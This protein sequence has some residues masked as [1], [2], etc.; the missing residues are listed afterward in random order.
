MNTLQKIRYKREFAMTKGEMIDAVYKTNLTKRA[1]LVVY[2]LIKE[3]I[4][5][6]Y[7]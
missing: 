3:A 5:V 6:R 7:E 4:G 2:Y 1:T